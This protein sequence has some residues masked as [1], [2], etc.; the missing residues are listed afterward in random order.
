MNCLY[1]KRESLCPFGIYTSGRSWWYVLE[2]ASI[3]HKLLFYYNKWPS[4][5]EHVPW[6][7]LNLVLALY[8]LLC[9]SKSRKC[10]Y[11]LIEYCGQH[12]KWT[13]VVESSVFDCE[14]TFFLAGVPPENCKIKIVVYTEDK[15]AVM[16][17]RNHAEGKIKENT[18]K[19]LYL[20]LV[21]YSQLIKKPYSI[22]I[23]QLHL[24]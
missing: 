3:P 17:C 23:H 21:H 1:V 12:P 5:Y 14:A 22:I 6:L 13:D 10:M 24:S 15:V 20:I 4:T 11:Q 16:R 19:Y 2:A 9:W 7:E 8:I 18:G